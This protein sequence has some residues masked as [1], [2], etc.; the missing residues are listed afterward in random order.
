MV[1]R[2]QVSLKFN[3]MNIPNLKRPPPPPTTLKSLDQLIDLYKDPL[4]KTTSMETPTDLPNITPLMDPNEH[5]SIPH[6][7]NHPTETKPNEQPPYAPHPPMDSQT[8]PLMNPSKSSTTTTTQCPP[9]SKKMNSQ[10][11]KF[12]ICK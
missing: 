6:L 11:P 12:T 1:I 8:Y 4:S 10:L 5:S 2:E 7:D 3:S 9:T